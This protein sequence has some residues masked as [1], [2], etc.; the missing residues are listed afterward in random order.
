MALSNRINMRG[1]GG[2]PFAIDLKTLQ[3][4]NGLEKTTA[5]NVRYDTQLSQ[6]TP[7]IPSGM[8]VYYN[9]DITDYDNNYTYY[10]FAVRRVGETAWQDILASFTTTSGKHVFNSSFDLSSYAG[11]QLE[12]KFGVNPTGVGGMI[13]KCNTLTIMQ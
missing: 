8:K 6:P 11:S 7:I 2:G 10:Q 1:G 5:Q 4:T 9:F 12:F 13:F 3:W